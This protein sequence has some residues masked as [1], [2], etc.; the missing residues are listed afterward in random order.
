MK[1]LAIDPGLYATAVV[2]SPAFSVTSGMRWHF[3]D[4]PTIGDGGLKRPDVRV[5]R[6]FIRR[7]LPDIGFVEFVGAMPRDGKMQLSRFMRA[8]GYLEATVECC[9][10]PM[11]RITPQRWKKFHGIPVGSDKE[12]SRD[13]ALKLIP[14]IAQWLTRKKDHGRAEAALLALFATHCMAPIPP[15]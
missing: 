10:V 2:Y 1:I 15:L 3:L 13:L 8:T 4:V 14:E 12:A 6:D 11:K 5:L 9:D 7:Y